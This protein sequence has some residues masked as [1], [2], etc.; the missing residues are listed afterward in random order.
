MRL[1]A[2]VIVFSRSRGKEGKRLAF[3]PYFRY[4]NVQIYGNIHIVEMHVY[5]HICAH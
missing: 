4:D 1:G 2:D 5:G 3:V